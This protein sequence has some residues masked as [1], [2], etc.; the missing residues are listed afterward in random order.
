MASYYCFFFNRTQILLSFDECPFHHTQSMSYVRM[1][2]N[3]SPQ[4]LTCRPFLLAPKGSPL[5]VSLTV[6]RIILKMKYT[7]PYDFPK[8]IVLFDHILDDLVPDIQIDNVVL[9]GASRLLN[10]VQ[11]TPQLSVN[12][13]RGT[14][15]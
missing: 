11:E 12:T 14:I 15:F 2:I 13:R 1:N 7:F 8:T 10:F 5:A 4:I 3:A 9:G 6:L